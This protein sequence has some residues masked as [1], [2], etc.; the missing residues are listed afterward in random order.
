MSEKGDPKKPS[1]H[2]LLD[3][4]FIRENNIIELESIGCGCCSHAITYTQGEYIEL[5][6]NGSKELLELALQKIQEL[7]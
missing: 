1:A 4:P 2:W 5:L 6:L 7:K 3:S